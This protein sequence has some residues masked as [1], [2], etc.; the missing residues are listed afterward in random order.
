VTAALVQLDTA[1][2]MMQTIWHW[3]NRKLGK[4]KSIQGDRSEELMQPPPELPQSPHQPPV[5]SALADELQ[6]AELSAQSRSGDRQTVKQEQLHH[7]FSLTTSP[8]SSSFEDEHL[9]PPPR[10]TIQ[11]KEPAVASEKD[12]PLSREKFEERP[13][14]RYSST[15]S[16][17]D[18]DIE[19]RQKYDEQ[20]QLIQALKQQL[21]ALRPTAAIGES[22][23]NRWQSHSAAAIGKS[24]STSLTEQTDLNYRVS[25]IL[26]EE[27]QQQA[28]EIASLRQAI[29]EAQRL[30]TIGE[31]R[32][33]RWKNRTYSK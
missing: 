22:W 27:L 17:I 21:L 28:N 19:A 20:A 7:Q 2:E 18:P 5:E 25:N 4:S 24:H 26:Q 10:A 15:G 14:T 16:T 13:D 12:L 31:A 23:V 30:S 33:N 6:A 1:G 3:L 9:S 11:T 32:L 8:D 29:Q